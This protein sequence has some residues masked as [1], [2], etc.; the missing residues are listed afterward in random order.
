M[1]A[2]MFRGGNR[3]KIQTR[4]ERRRMQKLIARQRQ[5]YGRRPGR[6][7]EIDSESRGYFAKLDSRKRRNVCRIYFQNV[8]TLKMEG[9]TTKGPF[10]IL[11][12]AGVDIVGIS[13]INKNWNHPI[14]KRRYE[15]GIHKSY[16]GAGI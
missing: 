14:I 10:G 6:V 1:S 13:E 16:P 3:N 8:R 12:A 5:V 11:R 9:D 2:N 4:K 7:N 15:K